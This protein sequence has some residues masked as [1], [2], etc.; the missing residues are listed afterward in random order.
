[1]YINLVCEPQASPFLLKIKF[2][3]IYFIISK[4]NSYTRLITYEKTKPK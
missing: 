1:M 4:M 2:S 3:K